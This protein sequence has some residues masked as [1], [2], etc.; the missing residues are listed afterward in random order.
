MTIGRKVPDE[1][2]DLPNPGAYEV[3]S[4]QSRAAARMLAEEKRK[5]DSQRLRLV[6]TQL[7][8]LNPDGQPDQLDVRGQ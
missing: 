3:G 1:I 8:A 7:A 5:R 6:N 2:V 4:L